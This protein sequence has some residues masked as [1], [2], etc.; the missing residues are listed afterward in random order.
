[1]LSVS[2][3]AP[4]KN[5]LRTVEA[6]ERLWREGLDFQLVFVAGWDGSWEAFDEAVAHLQA[7]GRPLRVLSRVD[8]DTLWEA[9]RVARCSV[10]VSL[11]EGFGLPAA[12]SLAV[13]TPVVLTDYGSMAEIGA[14][15][16]ALLVDPR[17]VDA[18]ADAMRRLLLDDALH[19]ELSAAALA[20]PQTDWDEYA[21]RTWQWLVDGEGS[22]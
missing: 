9:Y 13:G 5:H 22:V 19:A 7:K 4:R 2:S 17:D 11:V 10:F 6:A 3:I 1:V 14:D 12:E 15:G 18:I 21:R 20:R 8:E 16:G